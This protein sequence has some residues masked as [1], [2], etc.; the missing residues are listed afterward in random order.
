MVRTE[1][2]EKIKNIYKY[3]LPGHYPYRTINSYIKNIFVDEVYIKEIYIFGVECPKLGV[4]IN[5]KYHYDLNFVYKKN[6]KNNY[7]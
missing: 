2:Y 5:L 3:N 6:W 7:F 1:K 4:N